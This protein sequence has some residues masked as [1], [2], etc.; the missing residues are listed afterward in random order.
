MAKIRIVEATGER[1]VKLGAST[2]IGRGES[3]TVCVED[4]TASRNHI[5]LRQ[6]AGGQFSVLDLGST[7][8]TYLNGRKVT[9]ARL[10]DG[11]ELV[12]GTTTIKFFDEAD[13]SERGG[14]GEELLIVEAGGSFVQ[15][16]RA[17]ET[18]PTFS[19]ESTIEDEQS[20]RKE[21]ERMRI[22]YELS[23]A[24]GAETEIQPILQRILEM[25]F[26]TL[27]A[28]RAA[29]LLIDPGSGRLVPRLV[30][31]R[32]KSSEK[33]ML[34][35]SIINE[36]IS[37]G[38]GVLSA[39]AAQDDRF[40]KAM[41]IQSAGVRSTMTVPILYHSELLG[42]MYLDSLVETG[43]FTERDL[44]VFSRIASHAAVSI[45][46][47]LV[48]K[49]FQEETRTRVHLQ[50]F[51]SPSVVDQL[52]TGSMEIGRYGEEHEVTLLFNDIRGFT[53]LS[54]ELKPSM[55]VDMLNEYFERMIKVLFRYEGTFDKY[56][57]DEMMAIFG[58]P[59]PL[60]DAPRR[61]VACARDML[62][63]LDDL[64]AEREKR[65]R[66]PLS[67]GMGIH[68]GPAVCG[69]IGSTQTMQY[70]A[71]GDTVNTAARLCSAA[72]PGEI[73]IS[74]K[75]ASRLDDSFQRTA[76]PPLKVKGKSEPLETFVVKRDLSVKQ[77]L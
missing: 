52:M 36:A 20:V 4:N 13:Q 24:M 26:D 41:S 32:S 34:S 9:H 6:A 22:A 72:G 77:S 37:T 29:I 44:D 50:R 18:R 55:V 7:H 23:Q 59:L 66:F 43:V 5:E 76:M 57:G 64:N 25:V 75:T 19:P 1:E 30:R 74:A 35:R 53:S 11:D 63:E 40:E 56:V 54:E 10:A 65:G 17:I 15:A 60:P 12:I 31:Q 21:Y 58:A 42:V 27:K 33:V 68:T 28:D 61:A 46:H 62:R 16:T 49:S 69:A 3:C 45:K 8:G 48:I 71:I 2:I 51:L 67:V 47:V 14:E 39:D 73:L 38:R 70:T